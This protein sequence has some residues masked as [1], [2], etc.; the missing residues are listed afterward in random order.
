M[1][2]IKPNRIVK[3]LFNMLW[4]WHEWDFHNNRQHS[5]ILFHP[6]MDHTLLSFDLLSHLNVRRTHAIEFI[7]FVVSHE[8]IRSWGFFSVISTVYGSSAGKHPFPLFLWPD[9]Y[10]H[11]HT[12]KK[13]FC[14]TK[15]GWLHNKLHAVFFFWFVLALNDEEKQSSEKKSPKPAVAIQWPK[16]IFN[17]SITISP[18]QLHWESYRTFVLQKWIKCDIMQM[19]KVPKIVSSKFLGNNFRI[20][21]FELVKIRE[22]IG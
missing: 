8:V 7:F 15:I 13:V 1:R 2:N 20:P 9:Q 11:T 6:N 10:I 14:K 4:N 22:H 21:K 18:A 5:K 16:M 3:T 17:F 19:S 12:Q